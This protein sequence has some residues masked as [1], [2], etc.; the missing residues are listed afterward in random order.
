MRSRRPHRATLK[1]IAI[2]LAALF[3]FTLAMRLHSPPAPDSP[4]E[5]RGDGWLLLHAFE[6]LGIVVF[7]LTV[8]HARRAWGDARVLCFFPPVVVYAF[9]FEDVNIQ[10]S[11]IYTYNNNAWFV[12][13][14]TMVVV[15]LGWCAIVYVTILTLGRSPRAAAMT[16]VEK[17]LLAGSM[18]LTID[19]GIDAT[20]FAYGLWVWD[21]GSWFGVPMMNFIGWF[22]VVFLWVSLRS[23]VE[24]KGLPAGKEARYTWGTTLIALGAQYPLYGAF[25]LFFRL[26]GVD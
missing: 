3:L 22:V 5:A 2:L 24:A 17:G 20:A 23:W 6:V 1:A 8:V 10:L 13:H 16:P 15:P 19:L 12:V 21:R 11:Q 9:V 7:A 25:I 18:A 26:W 4:G 14:N